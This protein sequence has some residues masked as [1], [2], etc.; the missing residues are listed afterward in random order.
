MKKE[1]NQHKPNVIK[2]KDATEGWWQMGLKDI[3]SARRKLEEWQKGNL[4]Q[5]NNT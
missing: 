4:Y 5:E 2:I 3:S 1:S